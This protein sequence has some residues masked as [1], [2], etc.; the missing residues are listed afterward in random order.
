[1][2]RVGAAL[3]DFCAAIYMLNRLDVEE[4]SPEQDPK[5][6]RQWTYQSQHG[7]N[8]GNDSEILS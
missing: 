3:E 1:M 6:S 5:A 8:N 7:N 4:Y 2:N